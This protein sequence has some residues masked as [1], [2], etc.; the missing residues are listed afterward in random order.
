[1][2]PMKYAK[3]IVAFGIPALGAAGLATGW[4]T[5]E[6]SEALVLLIGGVITAVGTYAVP[7]AQ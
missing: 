5:T 3:A 7:N 2:N 1:M 6:A 4:I